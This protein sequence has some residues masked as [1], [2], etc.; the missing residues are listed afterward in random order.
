MWVYNK[1][2][3][4]I[5]V[6]DPKSRFLDPYT[7]TM[8]SNDTCNVFQYIH[9]RRHLYFYNRG[10]WYNEIDICEHKLMLCKIME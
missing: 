5:D 3:N 9:I 10:G 8:E 6:C 7:K 1:G 4:E 2:Y